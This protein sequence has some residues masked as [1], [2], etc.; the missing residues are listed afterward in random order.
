VKALILAAGEGTRLRP[1]TLDR[2]KPMLRVGDRP[3]LEHLI[4]LLR[5]H[6]VTELAIN[7]HYKPEAIVDYFG[8]GA[9]FGVSITYSPEAELLGS[10]GAVKRLAAFL[11]E[12]FLVV[13]GD[14]LTNLDLTALIAQHQSSGAQVTVALSEVEEPT[15]CGIVELTDNGRIVRF[16]EKPAA[17]AVFSNLANAG[18]YVVEPAVL[19]YIPANQLFDFGR[20]LFPILL[21][22]GVPLAGHRAVGYVLDIGSPERYQQAEAD[23]QTGRLAPDGLLSAGALS[24]TRVPSR[25]A[26]ARPITREVSQF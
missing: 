22:A 12:T 20:D 14:V 11:T 1:L 15:R 18:V 21:E 13:Y 4:D 25:R 24:D 17:E 26:P 19:R 9:R 6:G 2:P 3:I 16:V 10:A 5:R 8:D 7:L 23:W